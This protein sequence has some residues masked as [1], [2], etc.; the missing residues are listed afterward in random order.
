M[1]ETRYEALVVELA[2]AREREAAVR[3]R[4][5]TFAAN[6]ST[7]RAELGNPFYYSGRPAS[8]PESEAHFTGYA[9]NEA[10]F[11]LVRDLRAAV[12]RVAAI[13][14]RLSHIQ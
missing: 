8:D 4:L 12:R 6:I 10:I 2:Q 14:E 11:A 7:V 3:S 9:S 5:Q 1:D 13:E